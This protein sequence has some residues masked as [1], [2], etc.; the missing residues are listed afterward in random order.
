M[1]DL[2]SPSQTA[3][4][5]SVA[6]EIYDQTYHL[7]GTDPAYMQ[8]LAATVDAKMRAVAAHGGTVDSLRVAVLAA[9]NI[10]DELREMRERYAELASSVTQAQRT[11]RSRAGSLSHVLD[12]AMEDTPDGGSLEERRVG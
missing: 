6:V 9:L 11:V 12:E 5:E 10:A 2:Q 4:V 8:G 7:R 3:V 1:P